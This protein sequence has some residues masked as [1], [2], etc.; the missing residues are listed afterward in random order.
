MSYTCA[1]PIK[2]AKARDQMFSFLQENFRPWSDICGPEYT[3]DP[4]YDP[5]RNLVTDSGLNY[6]SGKCRIG[7][8]HKSISGGLSHYIYSTLRWMA[9]QVGKRRTFKKVFPKST[10]AI[11]YI[12]YDGHEAWPVIR[13]RAPVDYQWC[14]VDK[15]GFKA[16]DSFDR[17]FDPQMTRHDDGC[18][19]AELVRLTKLWKAHTS[20]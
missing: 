11:P 15:D 2:N 18:I 13:K 1:T 12:V 16:S 19:K 17:M 9:L 3:F 20:K 14:L 7:F 5:S 4:E 6:D 10:E 8:N